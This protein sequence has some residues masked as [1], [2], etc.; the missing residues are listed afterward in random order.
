MICAE[1][2]RNSTKPP[3]KEILFVDKEIVAIPK[4]IHSLA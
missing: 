4:E 1:M 3:D 2:K